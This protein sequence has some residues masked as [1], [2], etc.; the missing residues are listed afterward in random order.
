MSWAKYAIELAIRLGG[1]LGRRVAV[2][3][4]DRAVSTEDQIRER[5]VDAAR[6]QLGRTEAGVYWSAVL[7]IDDRPPYPRSWCGAGYLWCL[8][9]AHP[10]FR[11][12]RWRRG[13]GISSAFA[14]SVLP[15]PVTAEPKPGDMAYFAKNQHHAVVEDVQGGLVRL[16][17]FNGANG[18]VTQTQS[19]LKAPA[20]YYSIGPASAQV[21][22]ETTSAT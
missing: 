7:P 13:F 6:S 21:V 15:F 8:H 4:G 19:A 3:V 2:S 10:G 9:Q 18:R 16:I 14:A 17:N 1:A 11:T 5:I 20:C 22:S 12:V